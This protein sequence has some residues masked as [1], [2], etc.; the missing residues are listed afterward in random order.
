MSKIYI[1]DATEN[2]KKQLTALLGDDLK[3]IV[4]NDQ[5]LSLATVS[6]D[7]EAVSVFLTSELNEEL[8]RSM[9]Q[10]RLIACRSTGFNNVDLEFAKER[11]ITVVNVPTYGD[12]TVAEYAFGLL[13]LLVRKL[14]AV[15][16]ATNEGQSGHEQFVGNDLAGKT[17]GV[18]GA[19]H[20]GQ[21]MLQ[22][23]KGFDMKLLAYDPAQNA[24]LA[25]KLNFQ[26]QDLDTLLAESDVVSLHVPLVA[27]NEHLMSREKLRL[28]KPTA[29]LVNTARGELVDTAALIEALQ[30]NTL[31]GAALDVVEGEKMLAVHEELALLRSHLVPQDQL[32]K[33]MEIDVLKKLPNVVLTNHNA[34]NTVEAIN[35]INSTTVD[36]IRHYFSG[37]PQNQVRASSAA[38]GKLVIVRHG[39][40]EWNAL[41]VWT[42]SRDVHLTEKGFHQAAQL[43][44]ALKD[45]HI[46]MAFTSQQ[47]RALETLEGILDASQQ[48]DVPFERSKALNERDYGDYT[49][50]NKW[51]VR[52]QIGEETFERVRRDWDY[53]VP[54]GETLKMVYERVVPYYQQVIAAKLLQGKN[55]LIVSHGNAIRALMKYLESVSDADVSKLEMLLGDIVTYEIN[56]QA[57]MKHK[58]IEKIDTSPT[59]A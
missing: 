44:Q 46:D 30:A 47:L 55:V 43:G 45:F 5:P 28:M 34:F 24:D 31:G 41:G 33:T 54:N 2:D 15:L 20:I 37:S 26:Y 42:G 13:L 59:K 56:D 14:P 25:A 22:I 8:I 57:L 52:D 19:G 27:G 12:H 11:D 58:Q 51:Q 48:F 32:L 6:A 10:L 3:D 53:P 7:A 36:N 40:S 18:I 4:F 1:Y 50:L 38:I 49:G 39:E 29:I 9:P 35:R 23:G 17:L 21:R 16:L